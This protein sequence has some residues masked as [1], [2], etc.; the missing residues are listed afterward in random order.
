MA[1]FLQV[2][3]AIYLSPWVVYLKFQ[4]KFGWQFGVPATTACCVHPALAITTRKAKDS[5]KFASFSLKR[6]SFSRTR[7]HLGTPNAW[8]LRHLKHVQRSYNE[9]TS[10]SISSQTEWFLLK[11]FHHGLWLI[12]LMTKGGFK[13]QPQFSFFFHKRLYTMSCS[14]KWWYIIL[15]TIKSHI[16]PTK[17]KSQHVGWEGILARFWEGYSPEI[18]LIDTWNYLVGHLKNVSQIGPFPQ[19]GV[20]TEKFE[21]TT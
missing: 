2:K 13:P 3:A 15:G 14:S 1:K 8:T 9:K 21:T 12:L 10:D 5:L 18:K 19:I 6:A 11:G 4:Q 20:K 7:Y 16:P 17:E